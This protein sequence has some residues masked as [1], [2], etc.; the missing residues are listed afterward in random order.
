MNQEDSV[1]GLLH[2]QCE[3]GK[4]ATVDAMVSGGAKDYADYRGMCGRIHGL[5][6]AQAR[7]NEMADR[8]RKQQ[9]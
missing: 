4:Q 2:K 3:D 8:L 7:I 9:E 5:A 6:M 1:L